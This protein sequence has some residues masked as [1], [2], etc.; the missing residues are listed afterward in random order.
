MISSSATIILVAPNVSEQMGG[1]AIKALQIFQQIKKIHPNTIQ[2][3][4]GRNRA[5]INER[6]KL[7][8]VFFVDD[9]II[10]I[11]LYRSVVLQWFLNIWFFKKAIALAENYVKEKN[12]DPRQ[13]ILHFTEP[14]TPVLPRLISSKLVNVFG[15]INGNIYYPEI[16]SNKET[17]KAKFRRI[18]H[19]PIQ[20]INKI[21]FPKIGKAD[22]IL[23]AGGERTKVSLLA[24]GVKSNIMVDSLDCGIKES[25][26]ARPRVEHEGTNMKFVYF[27]RLVFHKCTFLIIQSLAKTKNKICLD[28][29]GR[30]PEL[31]HCQNLAKAL[32]LEERVNFLGWYTSHAELFDSL[33]NYRGFVFPSIEDA[34]GIAVQ[35][36]MGIGLPVICLDW[37][38]PQLLVE[39]GVTGY[40]IEPKSEELITDEIAKYL[41]ELAVNGELA[42]KMS[43]AGREKA[44]A[45]QWPNIIR[46]WLELYS[47][48]LDKS[49]KL[50][51]EKKEQPYNKQKLTK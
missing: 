39:Q 5:E 1:E 25:L 16:F 36:A 18:F 22:L 43:I 38:G 30:G 50:I 34:N 11:F 49:N 33:K 3:T 21:L 32:G 45:W 28:V 26:L 19:F 51:E 15:P 17:I 35:E 7:D 47:G 13:V 24:A 44:K 12:L 42:E 23:V 9:D 29:V 6:L 4:H 20:S 10:D 14:N 2:I 8:D 37:G 48:L 27:G 40:L 41:D 31:E 46:E